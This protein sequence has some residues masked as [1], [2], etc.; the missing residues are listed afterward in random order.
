MKRRST[1]ITAAMLAATALAQNLNTSVDIRYNETPVIPQSAPLTVNPPVA[2]PRNE[3]KTLPLSFRT[4]NPTLNTTMDIMQPV[5]YADTIAE[6]AY[7]GYASIGFMPTFNMAASAGYKFIDTDRTRLNAWLQYDGT[8]YRGYYP[9][10]D[11]DRYIRKH[12]ALIGASLHAAVG[13]ESFIDA[14]IDYSYGRFNRYGAGGVQWNNVSRVGVSALWTMRHHSINYGAGMGFDHDALSTLPFADVLTSPAENHSLSSN[15]FRAQIF[16]DGPMLYATS[17]GI[18]L[19]VSH[20]ANGGYDFPFPDKQLY[21]ASKSNTLLTV[22]PHYRRTFGAFDLDLGANLEFTFGTHSKMFNASPM[23]QASLAAGKFVKFYAK[24]TGGVIQNTIHNSYA[25]M[26]YVQQY[27]ALRNSH[28]PVDACVGVNFGAWRGLWAELAFN[29]AVA[30]QWQLPMLNDLLATVTPSAIDIRGYKL[31]GAVGYA[32]KSYGRLEA[33]FEMAPQKTNRGYYLWTDRAR[34]VAKIALTVKPIRPLM[35]NVDWQWR[36]DRSQLCFTPSTT[37]EEYSLTSL[38][39][40]SN[41]SA[42]ACYSI[43]PQWSAFLSGNNLLGRRYL[44]VGSVEGQGRT[45]LVGVN[46]KF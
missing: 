27:W 17:A 32:Y 5:A 20:V 6:S 35:I 23:V 13:R 40:I 2:T 18:M 26:P 15:N 46:Y 39:A 28:V 43:T 44:L 8:T 38:G 4:V 16:F 9:G 3:V 42:R 34:Y 45:G 37:V 14:G 41:L 7:R 12:D 11:V 29:Y 36:G 33:S 25:L 10:Q 19:K 24:A 21:A 1:I 30:D 31:R 22:R